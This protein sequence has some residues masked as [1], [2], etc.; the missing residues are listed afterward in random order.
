LIDLQIPKLE[1]TVQ[2]ATINIPFKVIIQDDG[3]P[4]NTL[5]RK[6]FG[7][8]WYFRFIRKMETPWKARGIIKFYDK[9]HGYLDHG[10]FVM[11]PLSIRGL[12]ARHGRLIFELSGVLPH[13]GR[14][15]FTG[16][17]ICSM[18]IHDAQNNIIILT[19]GKVDTEIYRLNAQGQKEVVE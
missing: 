19:V 15:C 4:L 17:G 18:D 7:W 10:D 12:W 16:W 2:M 11:V 5:I 13:I 9:I 8:R 14:Y 1:A 3:G 6:T